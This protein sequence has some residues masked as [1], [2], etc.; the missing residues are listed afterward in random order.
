MVEATKVADIC[1]KHETPM[2][3][4]L[5]HVG[6]GNSKFGK[7][8]CPLCQEQEANAAKAQAAPQPSATKTAEPAPKPAA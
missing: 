4:Q 5:E 6:G 8:F 3:K 1:P 7:P 2:I